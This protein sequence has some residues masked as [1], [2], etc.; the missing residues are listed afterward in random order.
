MANEM[1]T[2]DIVSSDISGH[3]SKS[4][5]YGEFREKLYSSIDSGLDIRVNI[6]DQ[7]SY[8]KYSLVAINF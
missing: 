7:V 3:F 1:S 5:K 6:E 4:T 8:S 2:N